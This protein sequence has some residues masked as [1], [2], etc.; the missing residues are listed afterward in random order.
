M[1]AWG[2]WVAAGLAAVLLGA[3][4]ATQPWRDDSPRSMGSEGEAGLSS[5]A[6]A[7]SSAGHA[8]HVLAGTPLAL[9]GDPEVEAGQLVLVVAG[10]DQQYS[11]E[12]ARYVSGLVRAGAT[13]VVFEE[14][15]LAGTLTGPFGIAFERAP[16]VGAP[17]G[18]SLWFGIDGV[19][20]SLTAQLPTVLLIDPGVQ[21]DV[22]GRSSVTALVDRDGDATFTPSDPGGTLPLA[23]RMTFGAGSVWAVGSLELV[24]NGRADD[25]AIQ[26]WRTDLL[27]AIAPAP[28]QV[29]V[30]E[31]HHDQV[32]LAAAGSWAIRATSGSPARWGLAGAAVIGAVALALAGAHWAPWGRHIHDPL[33][34]RTRAQASAQIT[35]RLA[36]T[37]ADLPDRRFWSRRASLVACA[38][39]PLLVLG[40]ILRSPAAVAA[41]LVLATLLVAALIRRD[42][43]VQADRSVSHE[44]A[45][46]DQEVDVRVRLVARRSASLEVRD[47]LPPEDDVV[48]GQNWQFLRLARQRPTELSYTLR[49][50]LRGPHS[51]GPLR[52]RSADPL[53]LR[54]LDTVAAEAAELRVLPRREPLK[55]A[56]LAVRRPAILMG[57][58]AVNRAGEGSEFH[59]LREYQAGDAMRSVNW[60]AS[61]RSKTLMVNQR[62]L[63]S[64]TL[65][66]MVLDAR[67]VT[68]CGPARDAPIAVGA[69]TAITIAGAAAQARDR[70]RFISFGADLAEVRPASAG[71]FLHLL[72]E[73]LSA[74]P[75]VGDLGFDVVAQRLVAQLKPGTP[76]LLLSGLEGEAAFGAGVRT[77]LGRG[78]TVT[79]LSLPVDGSQD[80]DAAALEALRRRNLDDVRRAGARVIEMQEGLPIEAVLRMQ[81]G[82]R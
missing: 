55:R 64:Q 13:L 6:Q 42:P 71:R 60:K 48:R 9:R 57:A 78:V 12:E 29:V 50:A 59:A 23:V 1:M 58:H 22:I 10:A 56:R 65:L 79:V 75:A 14:G 81:G 7:F 52:L 82:G 18:T 16:V 47:C 67:A 72:S 44:R 51:I 69:R 15:G 41:A 5:F 37:E 80:E 34:Y 49:P 36:A 27:A 30:D 11:S 8:V 45:P 3:I 63:E 70:I 40:A 74:L 17:N 28:R 66:T 73:H 20:H 26:A 21:A 54:V 31:S 61:A 77:L 38:L 39:G 62:V 25:P 19:N 53:Q 32:G 24:S 76:L 4:V 68:A 33:R 43:L 46:E 35:A 2:R